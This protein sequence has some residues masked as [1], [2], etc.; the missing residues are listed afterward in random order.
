[1]ASEDSYLPFS[2]RSGIAPIPAQLKLGKVSAELRRLLDYSIAL[3]F[4]REVKSGYES[5][6]FAG[7]WLR[8][9]QDLHVKFLGQ[10]ASS[11]R[12]KPSELR[13]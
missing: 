11:Y 8:V 3:E 13:Q 6:Y 9:A 10:S 12:N 2:Q 7:R 4:Q 1:M 5:T